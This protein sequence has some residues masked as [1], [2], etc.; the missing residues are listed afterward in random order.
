MEQSL[1]NPNAEIFLGKKMNLPGLEEQERKIEKDTFKQDGN[2][3]SLVAVLHL[4]KV[5]NVARRL[6]RKDHKCLSLRYVI[7]DH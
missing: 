5:W 2:K 6:I 3:R 1:C 7:Q 4:L